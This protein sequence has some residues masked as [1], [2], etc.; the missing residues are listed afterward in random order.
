MVEKSKNGLLVGLTDTKGVFSQAKT[1]VELKRNLLNV[2]RLNGYYRI[3]LRRK[4]K[5]HTTRKTSSHRNILDTQGLDNFFELVSQLKDTGGFLSDAE[6]GFSK[7][8]RDLFEQIAP[9]K[10]D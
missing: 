1:L 8:S 10:P 7:Q 3:Y 6:R 9:L 2:A 4:F 5:N